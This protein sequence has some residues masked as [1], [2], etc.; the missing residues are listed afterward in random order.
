MKKLYIT[1]FASVALLTACEM[2]QLPEGGMLTDE[3]KNEVIADDAEKLAG[4]MN[5]LKD[6]LIQY[7]TISNSS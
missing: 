4:D 1:V 6:N 5:A 3:Q 7:G 2:D